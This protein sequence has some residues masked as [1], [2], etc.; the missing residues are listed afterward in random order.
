MDA[1]QRVQTHAKT[2]VSL[3]I[4]RQPYRR[5]GGVLSASVREL[6]QP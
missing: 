1:L 6:E 4:P 5:N 3:L 2:D